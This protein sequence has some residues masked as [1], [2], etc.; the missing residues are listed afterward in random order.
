MWKKVGKMITKV[1][2]QGKLVRDEKGFILEA[3]STVTLIKTKNKNIIVDTGIFGEENKIIKNL[4][5][6]CL[7]P[8]DID[9]VINTHLHLDHIG[10]NHLFS[11]G[12]FIAHKKE[13]PKKEFIKIEGD[14]NLDENIKIFETP[15]H[16]YG[17]ISVAVKTDKVYVIAGDALPIKDN[18]LKWVPPGIN[19]GKKIALESMEK[20]VKIADVVIPGHDAPF[21]ISAIT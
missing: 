21:K 18:Y 15:G 20:I 8:K 16:T 17:S 1:I 19:I 6:E 10:N 2:K 14:Y 9:I 3:S 7:K 13:F 4:K 11:N 12:K 5:K